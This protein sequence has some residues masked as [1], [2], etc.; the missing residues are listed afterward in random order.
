MNPVPEIP[1]GRSVGPVRAEF[2]ILSQEDS[3]SLR[4]RNAFLRQIVEQM[5]ALV[6]TDQIQMREES[7]K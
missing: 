5:Q 1:A 2:R 6:I 4:T 3:I 7:L